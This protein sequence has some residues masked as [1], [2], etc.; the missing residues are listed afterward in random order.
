MTSR[1]YIPDR[2]VLAGGLAGAAVWLVSLVAEFYG[3]SVSSDVLG[4]ALSVIMP[5]VA[6][7]V[8]PSIADVAARLDSDLRRVFEDR[9][10]SSPGLTPPTE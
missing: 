10:A 9:Q 1:K 3:V 2:K 7:A 5:L 6:W 4:A 8:P